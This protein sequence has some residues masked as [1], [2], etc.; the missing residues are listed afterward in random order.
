MNE[1]LAKQCIS[2]RQHVHSCW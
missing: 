2:Y 1:T